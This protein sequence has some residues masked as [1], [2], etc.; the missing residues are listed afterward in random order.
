MGD[1]FK[2]RVAQELAKYISEHDLWQLVMWI[3]IV[4]II[5]FGA[6]AVL[7]FFY[8]RQ[9]HYAEVK[10]LGAELVAAKLDAA[11]KRQESRHKHTKVAELIALH[12]RAWLE[13]GT[14]DQAKLDAIR[15]ETLR[16]FDSEYIP[17]FA[18]Y[19]EIQ[20][21]SLLRAEK[22]AFANEEVISFLKTVRNVLDA[23]NYPA[24][25][26]R[27]DRQPFKLKTSTLSRIRSD[28]CNAVPW[29]HR[30]DRKRF[31]VVRQSVAVH[32]YEG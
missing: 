15:E 3:A 30:A 6:G 26:K 1:D 24:I 10:K 20:F 18:D 7:G 29:W 31:K 28:Y 16:L 25:L 17:T 5:L 4:S 19:A 32:E 11:L 14:G 12:L 13:A 21:A 8:K 2:N 27:L 23:V 22:R 9:R